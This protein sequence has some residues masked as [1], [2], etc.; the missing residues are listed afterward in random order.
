MNP[1]PTPLLSIFVSGSSKR[2]L[3]ASVRLHLGC[4]D[5]ILPGWS[6]IDLEGSRE[7]IVHDLTK[8]LPVATGT[9]QFIYSEHFI[10]HIPLE[11]ARRLLAECHRVLQPGGVLRVSTP[12]LRKLVLEYQAGRT[13]EWVDVDWNPASPCQMLNEGMRSWGHEFVYDADELELALRAAG[14]HQL[15]R[16]GWRASAH[17]EL[18]S[19]ECRPFHDELIFEATR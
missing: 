11:D 9:I 3:A 18:R 19:L 12:D 14:F 5:N 4:G 7:V 1:T 15:K 16:V 6:N 10:E 17:D 2:R 8:P 13:S